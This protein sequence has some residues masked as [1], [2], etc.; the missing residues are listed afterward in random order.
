MTDLNGV[1]RT[2]SARY[3]KDGSE[4][5]IPQTKGLNPRRLTPKECKNLMGYPNRF[6]I[7]DTGVSDTQ[8]YKQFGNS[9]VLPVVRAVAKQLVLFIVDYEMKENRK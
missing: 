8:L 2:L 1:S 5:L 4:V 9:V 6:K 7:D 3:Y